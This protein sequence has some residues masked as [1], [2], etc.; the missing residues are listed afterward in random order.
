MKK[1]T[2]L[3]MLFAFTFGFSQS[4]PITF[5]SDVIAG[6]KV[7]GVVS[8][9]DANW[10]SDSGLTSVSIE[11]LPSD[12]P[13]HGNAG[14]MVSSASGQPWQNA[15]ILS[16]DNYIDLTTNKVITLDVYSDNPQ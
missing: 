15:Q 3:S 6:A 10:Y 7:D 14:K 11:D 5:D 4:I 2:L 13:D 1:I 16:Q 8:P 9:L 12:S